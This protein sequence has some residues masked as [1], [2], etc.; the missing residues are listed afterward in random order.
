MGGQAPGIQQD[1]HSHLLD[2]SEP[3]G[4]GPSLLSLYPDEDATQPRS[5]FIQASGLAQAP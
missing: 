4:L 2:M 5:H 1:P 3:L